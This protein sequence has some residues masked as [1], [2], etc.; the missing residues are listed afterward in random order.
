MYLVHKFRDVQEVFN[1]KFGADAYI[2]LKMEELRRYIRTITNKQSNGEIR[3][4]LENYLAKINI[5]FESTQFEYIDKL[6]EWLKIII[7]ECSV[8]QIFNENSFRNSVATNDHVNGASVFGT[9][10]E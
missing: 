10:N 9:N 3:I 1:T 5:D 6:N 2:N 8:E 4:S 7:L